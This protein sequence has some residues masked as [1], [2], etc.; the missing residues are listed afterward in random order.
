MPH[1]FPSGVSF[2][3]CAQKVQ[4][5]LKT[6]TGALSFALLGTVTIL[7]SLCSRIIGVFPC[8]TSRERSTAAGGLQ[9][10]ICSLKLWA[11]SK[12]SGDMA[13]PS[14]NRDPS[15]AVANSARRPG[16]R[17]LSLPLHSQSPEAPGTEGRRPNTG[18]GPFIRKIFSFANFKKGSLGE[19]GSRSI[20]RELERGVSFLDMTNA[21]LHRMPPS[22]VSNGGTLTSPAE[23]VGNTTRGLTAELSTSDMPYGKV[24]VYRMANETNVSCVVHPSA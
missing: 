19:G 21:P 16:M 13:S 6:L 3:S 20:N 23:S 17:P 9:A 10:R 24:P 11:S 12:S 8:Q 14:L 7:T 2:S 4:I 5:G 15:P 1:L 18:P 22:T